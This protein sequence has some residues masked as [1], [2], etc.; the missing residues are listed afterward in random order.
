MIEKTTLKIIE[1]FFCQ[2]HKNILK[3]LL[4]ILISY[5]F[6]TNVTVSKN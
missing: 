3:N 1:W 2:F 5:S 4:I 6:V